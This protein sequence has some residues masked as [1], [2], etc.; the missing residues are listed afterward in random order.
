MRAK[1]AKW[2]LLA[3]AAAAAGCAGIAPI[4]ARMEARRPLVSQQ[5]IE[6]FH[7]A[8]ASV[9][10]LEYGRA[11]IAFQQALTRFEAAGDAKY[12]SQ[13]MF[14]LG[15]CREMQGQ[16]N[17][18]VMTYERVLTRYPAAPAAGL[19]R[20]RLEVLSVPSPGAVR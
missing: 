15:Y 9:A 11:G 10:K 7:E 13:C 14:W 18:A 16:I 3:A 12:A 5:D 17:E 20:R 1:A 19:A 2:L 8:V 6:D 4:R